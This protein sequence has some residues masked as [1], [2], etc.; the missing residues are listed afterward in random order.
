MSLHW[1]GEFLNKILPP[2]L[3]ARLK[4]CNCDSFYDKDDDSYLH[5]NG[6]TG[7]VILAMQGVL[8]KRVSRRKLRALLS[9]GIDIQ[10]GSVVLVS[11][12]LLTG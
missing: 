5:C 6:Q 1:G 12:S 8:P 7:D 4:E 10:V 3:K 2:D 9:E 11:C